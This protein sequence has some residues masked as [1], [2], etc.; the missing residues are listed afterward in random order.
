MAGWNQQGF[1]WDNEAL[2][3]EVRRRVLDLLAEGRRSCAGLRGE[4]GEEV[5]GLPALG[6]RAVDEASGCR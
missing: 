2:K 3:A 6:G 4:L 5:G 1:S